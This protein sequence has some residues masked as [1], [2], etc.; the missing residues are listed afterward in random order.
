MFTQKPILS[1]PILHSRPPSGTRAFTLIELLTVIAIIGILAGI[2]IPVVGK[3][4]ETARNVNCISSLRNIHNWLTLYAEENK[5][6]YPQPSNNPALP[7]PKDNASG[8]W[9]NIIQAYFTPKFIYPAVD[10]SNLAM[11][12]WYCAAAPK[13]GLYPNGVRRVYAINA[14]G[15]T[16]DDRF[17][18]NQNTKW[19]QTLIVADGAPWNPGDYDSTAYFRA[20]NS[21]G[22]SLLFDP[23]HGGK[24]NGVFLD[25]HVLSFQLNDTRLD[26]WIKN[27]RN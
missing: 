12:P 23:R 9:W 22:G 15:G 16:P 26:D 3:V 17:A 13:G 19:S 27:L 5:G 11:N 24:I 20:A 25:G 4:R 21:G 2:M 6:L 18:P 8:A 7:P 14:Q 1:F 10:E